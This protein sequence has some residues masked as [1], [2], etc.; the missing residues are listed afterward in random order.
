MS[1]LVRH[2]HRLKKKGLNWLDF[3][4]PISDSHASKQLIWTFWNYGLIEK[5]NPREI[6]N[7]IAR[8]YLQRYPRR[9]RD[10]NE[11]STKVYEVIVAC[12]KR[13]ERKPPGFPHTLP[14]FCTVALLKRIVQK[15][16]RKG[17]VYPFEYLNWTKELREGL[18]CLDAMEIEV[19]K[20]VFAL[21]EYY[22]DTA[23]ELLAE[24]YPH[25]SKQ[26]WG[27]LGRKW[28][29]QAVRRYGQI[30]LPAVENQLV[31]EYMEHF[32]QGYPEAYRK[33]PLYTPVHDRILAAAY[34]AQN[35]YRPG[36]GEARVRRLIH[37]RFPHRSEESWQLLMDTASS[38]FL[39]DFPFAQCYDD[40]IWISYYRYLG[41]VSIEAVDRRVQ[42][43]LGEEEQSEG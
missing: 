32:K 22:Q 27:W 25:R 30:P 39:L 19:V 29:S 40:A 8:L 15:H 9:F 1:N 11:I 41:N 42:E 38:S 24:R 43:R 12:I 4:D 33:K 13:M 37:V 36:S 3:Y 35:R 20:P 34:M 31:E 2:R 10:T 18:D 16:R 21:N 6:V 17:G 23:L 26:E 5:R 28:W 14:A 7:T